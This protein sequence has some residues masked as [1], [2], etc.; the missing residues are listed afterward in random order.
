MEYKYGKP[1][2]FET[3]DKVMDKLLK[4]EGINT[5]TIS[6]EAMKE[7]SSLLNLDNHT[8]ENEIRG[9]RNAV[10]MRLG[11]LINEVLHVNEYGK[12]IPGSVTTKED[13]DKFEHLNS[14][15]S[16]I[17]A[18]IDNKLWNGGYAV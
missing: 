3:V 11:N 16:A 14:Y 10:V 5:F 18:V 7:V 6:D 8:D 4:V 1:F 12:R 13:F 17:T 9:I 2:D 15:M